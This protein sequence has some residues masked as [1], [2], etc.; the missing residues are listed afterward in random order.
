[1]QGLIYLSRRK[2][3]DVLEVEE[4]GATPFDTFSFEADPG[5]EVEGDDPKDLTDAAAPTEAPTTL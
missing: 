1:M 3:G 2:A 5:D 4:A